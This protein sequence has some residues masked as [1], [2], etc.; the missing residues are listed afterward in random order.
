MTG[1]QTCALPISCERSCALHSSSYVEGNL[2]RH[3]L[4]PNGLLVTLTTVTFDDLGGKPRLTLR[5]TPYEAG[6]LGGRRLTSASVKIAQDSKGQVIG[7]GTVLT[8]RLRL[9]KEIAA[10]VPSVRKT[11][12]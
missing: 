3:P 8:C 12:P 11:W 5:W 9:S 7:S 10:G 6:S 2:P 4:S 1:V